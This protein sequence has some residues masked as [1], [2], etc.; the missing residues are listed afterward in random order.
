MK[1]MKKYT[2]IYLVLFLVLLFKC[3]E[4]LEN[5][6]V[7]EVPFIKKAEAVKYHISYKNSKLT[8]L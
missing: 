6:P 5:N 8:N 7:Y 2:L 1:F 4:E 3:S